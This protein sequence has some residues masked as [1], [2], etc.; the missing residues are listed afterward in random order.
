MD[1]IKAALFSLVKKQVMAIAIKK[2]PILG[3]SILNPVLGLIVGK[4]LEIAFKETELAIYF[5]KI[6]KLTKEQADK[7]SKAQDALEKAKTEKEKKDAE[8]ELKKSL[9]D[10]IVL[11]P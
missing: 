3:S 1:E 9:L 5:Y 11:K 8:N 6:D 10:L 4:I 2:I 7:V